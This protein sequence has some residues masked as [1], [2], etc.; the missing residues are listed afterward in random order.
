[1]ISED[2]R[3]RDMIISEYTDLRAV[4]AYRRRSLGLSQ[5]AVDDLAG[6][7]HGYTGKIECGARHF[8]DLSFGCI[9]GAL[10]IVLRATTHPET[11]TET[12]TKAHLRAKLERNIRG[13]AGGLKRA[14]NSSP[15]ERRAAARK[16]AKTR[17]LNWRTIREE[18]RDKERRAKRRAVA[19]YTRH[20]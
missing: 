14:A 7:Q 16:A 10:G 6:V 15:E 2:F 3:W 1:M 13:R 20:R 11:A 19:H 17:W 8:G 12:W 9:M 18:K 4:V 5:M